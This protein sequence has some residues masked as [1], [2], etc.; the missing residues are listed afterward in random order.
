MT[1]EITKTKLLDIAVVKTHTGQITIKPLVQVL[2]DFKVDDTSAFN[3]IALWENRALNI[4]KH[5]TIHFGDDTWISYEE[6]Q[7]NVNFKGVDEL[8]YQIRIYSL[9]KLTHGDVVGGKPL[10]ISTLQ[11]DVTYLNLIAAFLRQRGYH[12]FHELEFKSDLV[13]RNLIKD[14]LY[15]VRKIAIYRQSHSFTKLFDV[16]RSFRLFG[17]K[18]C[19]VFIDVLNQLNELHHPRPV[20]Y[21]HPVIPTKVMKK[22]LK[23]AEKIVENSKDK[24]ERW[25]ELNARL[26]DSL[27]EGSVEPP[28]KISTGELIAKHV[29]NLPDEV[30]FIQLSEE[31]EDLKLA[32][33]IN[34]LAY[35]GMRYNEVLTCKVGCANY[36]DDIYYITAIMTKTDNSKVEMEWFSN[37][38]V[39]ECVGI[40]EKYVFGM[41]ERAK[42]VLSSCRANI[43]SSQ[44]HNLKEGLERNRLFGVSHSS[45]SVSFSDAG[46]FTKFEVKNSENIELFDLTLDDDDIAELERLESNY[47]EV[48]GENR[49]VPYE[50]GDTFRLTAH[51][52]RHTLAYFVI[53]NKLGELDDIRYQFKHLTSLMTFVYTRRAFLASTTLI[54]TTEEFNEILIDRVAE[55]LIDEAESQS[56]KGGAGEQINKTSKDLIIGI[57]DSQSKDS[58]VI[59][60]IHFSSIEELKKF[61]VKNIKNIRGLPTGYC[62]AGEA[63]KIKGAGIPS[64]CVYCG[65][66]IITKRHKVNWQVIKKDATQ[67]LEAYAA[68]TTEEQEDYELFAIHWKNN[69][70]A[71]D[72]VLDEGKAHTNQGEQA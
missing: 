9:I 39:H 16:Q 49:G 28:P 71:A 38:E 37:A 25:L 22:I 32:T 68:S 1:K 14:Y 17:P 10:K 19:S 54:K 4:A 15:E 3:S 29:R 31:L 42:A 20:T 64:G 33:Y 63:C 13:I 34:I 55:E 6:T 66:K 52:F 61:L 35:T 69:I 62:T 24:I 11:N 45:C 18:V 12:S 27:N 30:E 58:T 26:I 40:Y 50:E 46:R 7:R 57:T 36:K 5:G 47:K 2:E 60:Q 67:K 53:A 56:L 65:S 70:A 41:Q 8:A 51:M 59:K 21:S 48:R 44:A 23:F 43:T 72:Y